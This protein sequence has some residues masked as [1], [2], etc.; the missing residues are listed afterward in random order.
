MH[1][2]SFSYQPINL[3]IPGRGTA[4]AA[5]PQFEFAITWNNIRICLR[6]HP[7]TPKKMYDIL[8]ACCFCLF[9]FLLKILVSCSV[10]ETIY[11][12]A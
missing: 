4:G 1:T 8:F 7:P 6:S 5:L 10:A 2:A 3:K 9:N 12:Q 11:F